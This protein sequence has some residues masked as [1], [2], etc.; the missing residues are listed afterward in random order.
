MQVFINIYI[1][2]VIIIFRFVLDNSSLFSF[3]CTVF[4]AAK[5]L[6]IVKNQ[7]LLLCTLLICNSLAM[8]VWILYI[9]TPSSIICYCTFDIF[10]LR[11][12][13]F[14]CQNQALP[15]F[16]DALLPAWGAILISV[17]LILAFGE[18][19]NTRIINNQQ[20]RQPMIGKLVFMFLLFRYTDYSTGSVL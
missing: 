2:A 14:S 5:I 6:P 4:S 15:I 7:H 16:L 20:M 8:E 19:S 3:F 9:Y 1:T 10:G 11:E 13:V 18:V 12:S 17:T